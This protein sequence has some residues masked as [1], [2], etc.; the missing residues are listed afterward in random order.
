[1]SFEIEN[2]KFNAYRKEG[3]A[4]VLLGFVQFDVVSD[5]GGKPV[6][7]TMKDWTIREF[8]KDGRTRISVLSPSKPLKEGV[9]TKFMNYTYVEG[10]GWWAMQDA[11]LAACGLAAPKGGNGASGAPALADGPRRAGAGGPPAKAPGKTNP[12]QAL[13]GGRPAAQPAADPAWPGV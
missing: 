4:S 5:F 6:K 12:Y 7:M 11:I 13:V 8:N 2:V 10:E 1:M 9:D 3:P